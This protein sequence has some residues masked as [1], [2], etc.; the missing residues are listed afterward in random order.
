[1][2]RVLTSFLHLYTRRPSAAEL[3]IGVALAGGPGMLADWLHS[4]VSRKS[5]ERS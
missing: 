1:M 3:K 2:G 5:A 4:L